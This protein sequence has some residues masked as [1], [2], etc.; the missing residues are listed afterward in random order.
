MVAKLVLVILRLGVS[1]L[2]VLFLGPLV[3]WAINTFW[4]TCYARGRA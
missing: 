3:L 2:W 4:A 1:F